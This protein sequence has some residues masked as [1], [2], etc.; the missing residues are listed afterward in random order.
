ML[1]TKRPENI[2]KMLPED[3]GV[4]WPHVWLGTTCENQEWFDRRWP[5][6]AAVPAR[7]R[8]VSYEP[9]IGPLRLYKSATV[10]LPFPHPDWIICGGES[11]HGYRKMDQEWAHEIKKDCEHLGV[12]F[13]FKQ[14][15]GKKPI[16]NDLLVRQFPLTGDAPPLAAQA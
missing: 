8:F 5:I 12:A 10:P 2:K 1:L 6:L 14:M 16:P 7:V 13:F 11:G 9:A 4:G 3:W 15:A